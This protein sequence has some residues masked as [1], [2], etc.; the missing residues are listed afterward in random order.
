MIFLRRRCVIRVELS[1]SGGKGNKKEEEQDGEVE[2]V[3]QHV[4]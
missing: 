4:S 3:L 1:Y 2:H